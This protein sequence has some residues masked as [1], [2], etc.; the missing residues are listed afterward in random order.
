[1]RDEKFF[2]PVFYLSS[3]LGE[4][5]LG[6]LAGLIA[7]DERFFFMSG[8]VA[9]QNYNYNENILLMNAIR[10][11]YRGA[12]W[13]ILRRLSERE[14]KGVIKGCAPDITI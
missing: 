6:Y 8:E 11:G 4:D 1:V 7:G 9:D 2:A 3:A 12:F 5:A 10:D 13:D 14:N